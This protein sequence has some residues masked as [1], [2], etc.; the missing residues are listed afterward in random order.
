MTLKG[1]VM[2][3]SNYKKEALLTVINAAK[4]NDIAALEELIRRVQKDVFTMFTYLT[5]NRQDVSDLTQDALLRMA[6]NIKNLHEIKS[7]KSWLNHIVTNIFN[8]YVKQNHRVLPKEADTKAIFEIRDKINCE[9]GEKCIFSEMEKLVRWALL[10]LPHNLRIVIVLR[11]Y[12]G[13]SY[14]DIAKI[15]KTSLGTVK[16]RI[17]RA[18]NKLQNELRDFI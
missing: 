18:R 13:M 4:N 14:E 1:Q 5:Q 17:S 8:D 9:P 12:E 16:S 7:F 6:K 15:T 11:E 3:K 2:Y 10:T